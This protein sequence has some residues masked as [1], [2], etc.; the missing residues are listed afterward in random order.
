MIAA[1]LLLLAGLSTSGLVLGARY[2]DGQAWR[3]SLSA[4][5]STSQVVFT[6]EANTK[7]GWASMPIDG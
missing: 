1:L 2:A 4:L 3:S 5:A 7:K 6:F